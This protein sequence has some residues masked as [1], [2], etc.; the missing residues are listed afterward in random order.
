[1]KRGPGRRRHVVDSFQDHVQID[2]VRR[3]LGRHDGLE[4]E[5]PGGQEVLGEVLQV[6][7]VPLQLL[8]IEDEAHGK[9]ADPERGFGLFYD[10]ERE[11]SGGVVVAQND[12][13][14]PAGLQPRPS[15]F[16]LC[17]VFRPGQAIDVHVDVLYFGILGQGVQK[18]AGQ[19]LLPGVF[20]DGSYGRR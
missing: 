17:R 3:F 10:P 18:T 14:R 20:L 19:V 9:E 1:M 2:D 8:G 7:G 12:Q 4:D 11:A 6:R 13:V 15:L 5:L 16:R